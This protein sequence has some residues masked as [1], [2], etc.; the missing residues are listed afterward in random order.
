[1][2]FNRPHSSSKKAQQLHNQL[3]AWY[4]TGG[5]KKINIWDSSRAS[6]LS[7]A[8]KNEF[9]LWAYFKFLSAFRSQA[10]WSPQRGQGA[11]VSHHLPLNH[12]VQP[13]PSCATRLVREGAALQHQYCWQRGLCDRQKIV[14][15]FFFC[16]FWFFVF[17]SAGFPEMRCGR[18]AQRGKTLDIFT[19]VLAKM[20]WESHRETRW[21]HM[22]E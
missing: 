16:C 6:N 20:S 21:P 12:K 15:A 14:A 13:L 19:Y 8:E 22:W 18:K 4:G 2:A 11:S 7:R 17:F 10:M 1:M 3:L 5:E 9:V